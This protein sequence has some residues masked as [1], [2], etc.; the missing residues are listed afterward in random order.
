MDQIS[1]RRGATVKPSNTHAWIGQRQIDV[2]LS[3][4]KW[5]KT[6]NSDSIIPYLLVCHSER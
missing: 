4:S 1:D 3:G 2:K 5:F 6:F